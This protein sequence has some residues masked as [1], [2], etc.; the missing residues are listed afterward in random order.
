[1]PGRLDN[2]RALNTDRWKAHAQSR[3]DAQASAAEDDGA[4]DRDQL[5][6][7]AWAAPPA[8]VVVPTAGA[9]F[10][11]ANPTNDGEFVKP[12]IRDLDKQAPRFRG[13]LTWVDPKTYERVPMPAGGG[14]DWMRTRKAV[15]SSGDDWTS[16]PLGSV[17][18]YRI[19]PTSVTRKQGD[20]QLLACCGWRLT[21]AQ[22]IWWLNFVCFCAHTAMIFVTLW[23]AYWRH[24]LNAFR[25]TAHVEIPI[26]RIRNVPTKYMLDNNLT[27]WSPGWNLTSSDPN[28]G[29]FLYDNGMPINFASL[30]VA[31]FATSA[32]AHFWAIVAGAYE[33][34]WFWYWRQLDDAFAY[35]RWAEYSVSASLMAMAMGITLG[36][37][38]QYALAGIFML[39]W[40]TQTYGFLTEYIS[41][42]KAYV[43]K[44]NYKYP[45]GPYQLQKFAEG[46][47]DYGLTDYYRDPN[48]LKLIDQT[49]WEA[50]RP[51]YDIKN[52]PEMPVGKAYIL[53]RAQRTANWLRRMVPHVF[54]W[55]TMT[56]VWFILFTQL[57]NARRDIDEIS[58]RNIPE[59]VYSAIVGTALIFMSFALVQI[60][61]QRLAPGFYF[62]TEIA[63][64][65][66]SLTAKMYLGWFLLINV[67]F[68]DGATVE[69]TLRAKNEVR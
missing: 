65:I 69:E 5:L 53:V 55:F 17:H 15:P 30:I 23:M 4:R 57:E 8:A 9:L 52:A 54:G 51:M 26:Y 45:V 12:Y 40:A 64:C 56:S 13:E 2:L 27:Q 39:T 50:D 66:L 19:P 34:W 35:W 63:Y 58:D 6:G 21:A 68:I 59:W 7:A 62:G 32:V 61:F 44:D 42:P 37:R 67:I 47:A 22:H 1:M 48:A 16:V 18:K 31:F 20:C 3:T 46:A 28:S 25:D 29:L 43:D 49:E 60:I 33:R 36:I 41:T 24:G 10:N 38:E 14:K 11:L